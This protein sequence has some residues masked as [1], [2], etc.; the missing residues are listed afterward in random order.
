MYLS[1]FRVFWI[2]NCAHTHRFSRPIFSE[3]KHRMKK[4]YSTF[5]T[6][7][8]VK[9]RLLFKLIPKFRLHPVCRCNKGKIEFVNSDEIRIKDFSER[10]R[11]MECNNGGVTSNLRF[12]WIRCNNGH[13]ERDISNIR[14]YLSIK[15]N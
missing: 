14:F 10:N 7:F 4:I 11:I 1:F 8:S 6:H 2:R 13:A 15:C 3:T 12:R 5:F 9:N